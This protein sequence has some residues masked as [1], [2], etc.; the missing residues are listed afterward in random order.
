LAPQ[1]QF[2]RVHAADELLVHLLD[3]RGIAGETAGIEVTHL[4]D[5]GLQLLLRLGTI[6]HGWTH[7]VERGQRLVDLALRIGGIRTFLRRNGVTLDVSIACVVIAVCSAATVITAG[8]AIARLTRL[9]SA[10]LSP[11]LAALTLTGLALT[12]LALTGLALTALPAALTL[13][14]TALTRLSV[15]RLLLTG[16]AA[17]ALARLRTRLRTRPAAQASELIPQTR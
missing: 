12:G 14:T 17:A 1:L 6:L 11:V 3:K 7:L 16:L 9:T 8:G 15:L 10:R 4:V 2:E 5:E 13:L